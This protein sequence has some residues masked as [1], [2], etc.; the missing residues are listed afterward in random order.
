MK[1]DFFD[2]VNQATVNLVILINDGKKQEFKSK[3]LQFHCKNYCY[4]K[5]Q[6]YRNSNILLFKIYWEIEQVVIKNKQ[7]N[8]IKQMPQY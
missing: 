7:I 1:N 5:D 8:Y 4:A 3:S 6:V 2:L